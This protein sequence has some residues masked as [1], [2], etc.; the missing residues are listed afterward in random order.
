MKPVVH[1]LWSPP[2]ALAMASPPPA[3]PQPP[4][5]S[6]TIFALSDDLLRE[7]FL[8][9]PSLPSL[10]RAALTCRAFLAAVRS[11]PAFRRHFRAAHP[12]PLLGFFFDSDGTKVSYFT[13]IC[14]SS[15]PDLAAAVRGAD[16]FLTRVTCPVDAFPGWQIMACQNGCL[17]LRNWI[18]PQIATYY[19]LTSALNFLPTPPDKI[20]HGHRGKFIPM[21]TEF[22]LSSDDETID[23]SSFRVATCYHD[24]SRV[25]VAIFSSATKEWRILPWSE[26][27]P[28]Q[29]AASTGCKGARW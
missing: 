20:S 12:P 17:V 22:S 18:N 8:H 7:I 13:P 29:P 1:S 2:L 28:L 3:K 6:T 19:P 9:L 11:S 5:N 26:P 14:R 15:D 23:R 21:G 10:V 24:K 4:R 16:V 27:M 25:R